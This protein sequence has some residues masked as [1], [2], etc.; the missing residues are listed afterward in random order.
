MKTSEFIRQAVDAFLSP[1]SAMEYD[2]IKS[3]FICICLDRYQIGNDLPASQADSVEKLILKDIEALGYSGRSLYSGAAQKWAN[4]R[5]DQDEFQ[6]VRFMYAE[7]LALEF[8]D[9]GD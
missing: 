3:I 7:F 2:D 5:I 4:E 1:L 6:Q 9:M 8:E